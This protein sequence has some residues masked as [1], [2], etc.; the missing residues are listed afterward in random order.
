MRF[1]ASIPRRR[2]RIPYSSLFWRAWRQLPPFTPL[3]LGVGS[4]YL[5][6]STKKKEKQPAVET[7]RTPKALFLK[8]TN[9]KKERALPLEQIK[10][11]CSAQDDESFGS[12]FNFWLK[13]QPLQDLLANYLSS[14]GDCRIISRWLICCS[15]CNRCV[16]LQNLAVNQQ[17]V[18]HLHS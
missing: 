18:F 2:G 6:C 5:I 1:M 8:K 7:A 10:Y 4:K 11:F 12:K 9:K 14:S 3:R 17:P 15:T 13:R 16:F